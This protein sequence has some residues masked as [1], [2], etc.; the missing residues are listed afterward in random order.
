MPTTPRENERILRI[1][2]EYLSPEKLRAMFERLWQK[3]GA[4]SANSSVRESLR[5]LRQLTEEARPS[6]GSPRA[7]E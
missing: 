2:S 4:G 6:P 5:A 1:A 3:V 7:T